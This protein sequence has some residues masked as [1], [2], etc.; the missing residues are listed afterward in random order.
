MSELN[1]KE[2]AKAIAEELRAER[3]EDFCHLT[4]GEQQAVRD[5]IRTKKHAVKAFLVLIGALCLWIV[6]D[7]YGWIVAH[8]TFK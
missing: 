2:L 5:L 8:L 6:K 1:I 7:A 4:G 3:P